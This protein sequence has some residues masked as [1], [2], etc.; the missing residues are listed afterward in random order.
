MDLLLVTTVAD[1]VTG[2]TIA[3][4]PCISFRFFPHNMKHGIFYTNA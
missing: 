2:S 1:L 3:N 4:K